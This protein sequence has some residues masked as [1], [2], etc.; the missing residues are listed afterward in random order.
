MNFRI[1]RLATCE[2]THMLLLAALLVVPGSAAKAGSACTHSPLLSGLRNVTL[3]SGRVGML[4]PN[5]MMLGKSALG[6]I[7]SS[8]LPHYVSKVDMGG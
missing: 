8:G 6:G 3:P 5:G 2:E 7:G 1:P 4:P